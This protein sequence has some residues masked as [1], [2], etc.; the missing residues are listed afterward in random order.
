M[1]LAYMALQHLFPRP[2]VNCCKLSPQLAIYYL[3]EYLPLDKSGCKHAL[4]HKHE[5]EFLHYNDASEDRVVTFFFGIFGASTNC[6]VIILF[7][8]ALCV[9]ILEKFFY[10]PFVCWFCQRN[11][12][13]KGDKT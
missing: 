11:L 3:G 1:C 7:F 4:P 6:R 5:G 10:T 2:V 9:E 8:L 13:L 12:I